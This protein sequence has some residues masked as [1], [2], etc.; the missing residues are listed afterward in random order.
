M[1]KSI[2][3]RIHEVAAEKRSVDERNAALLAEACK[4]AQFHHVN[5]QHHP[6]LDETELAIRYDTIFLTHPRGAHLR[7]KALGEHKF[8]LRH[9]ASK[10]FDTM[11]FEGD[12]LSENAMLDAVIAFLE[13]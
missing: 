5:F 2:G 12:P 6:I 13:Q 1:M 3:D 7:I 10:S 4:V 9:D 11:S 8:L